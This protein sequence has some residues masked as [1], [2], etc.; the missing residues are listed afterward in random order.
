MTDDELLALIDG[1]A[2]ASQLAVVGN[3]R[4]CADRC[5]EIAPRVRV[6]VSAADLQYHSML[7]GKWGEMR[8]RAFDPTEPTSV[9]VLCHQFLDQVSAGRGIDLTLPQVTQ[10]LEH[11]TAAG[12][13]DQAAITAINELSWAPATIDARDV[14]RVMM[15]R[16]PGGHL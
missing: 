8:V 7:S 6:P 11:L 10:M 9:R 16:R 1:D 13:V 14:S 3:D 15:P 4:E 2:R 5:V 12:L